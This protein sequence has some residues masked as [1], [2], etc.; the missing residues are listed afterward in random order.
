MIVVYAKND[1]GCPWGACIIPSADDKCDGDRSNVTRSNL[2]GRHAKIEE[3]LQNIA[4]PIFHVL[5]VKCVDPDMLQVRI[6]LD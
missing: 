4:I 5:N 2:R 6:G 3:W 1:G